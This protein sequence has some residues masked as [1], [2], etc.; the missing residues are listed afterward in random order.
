VRC[1]RRRRQPA[2]VLQA[3][4]AA[5]LRAA[6]SARVAGINTEVIWQHSQDGEDDDEIAEVFSPTPHD[7]AWARAYEKPRWTE[8]GQRIA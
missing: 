6:R 2:L 3:Q 4:E 1:T 8:A 7:M 5:Q